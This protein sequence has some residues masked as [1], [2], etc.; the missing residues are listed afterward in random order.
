M[1]SSSNGGLCAREQWNDET[2][3]LLVVGAQAD[4]EEVRKTAGSCDHILF[5]TLGGAWKSGRADDHGAVVVDI[6]TLHSELESSSWDWTEDLLAALGRRAPSLSEDALFVTRRQIFMHVL[7]PIA[8][9]RARAEAAA[10]RCPSASDVRYCGVSQFEA[11]ALEEVFESAHPLAVPTSRRATEPVALDRSAAKAV[12]LLKGLFN[13]I[14]QS[15]K[16]RRRSTGPKALLSHVRRHARDRRC[17]TV[18]TFNDNYMRLFATTLS[19]LRSRGWC[20][21]EVQVSPDTYSERADADLFDATVQLGDFFPAGTF[22]QKVIERS[23][24]RALNG[25]IHDWA[26]EHGLTRYGEVL[27]RGF[28]RHYWRAHALV[29]AHKSVVEAIRP[30]VVLCVNEIDA[31][32]EA[33]VPAARRMGVPTVDVQHG[34]IARTLR[35]ANLDFDAICV[36]GDGYSEVLHSLGVPEDRTHVVGN[37]YLDHLTGSAPVD[38]TAGGGSLP[39]VDDTRSFTILFAAQYAGS[40]SSDFALYLSLKVVLE[41]LAENPENRLVLK[42]HPL[43]EGREVGYEVALAQ[44]PDVSVTMVRRGNLHDLIAK[45]DC[46]VTYS[47]TVGIEA[48]SFQKPVIVMS[49]AGAHEYLP[50]VNEGVGF[51]ATNFA[52]FD[53]CMQLIRSG[54]AIPPEQYAAFERRYAFVKDGLAGSRIADV[55]EEMAISHLYQDTVGMT[56][57]RGRRP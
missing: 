28:S 25:L 45:C 12:G 53:R 30:Q 54:S 32:V 10:S 47:S 34:V 9:A 36:F 14:G 2:G 37:P 27:A 41:W 55:C 11:L 7:W 20:L 5:Y 56:K 35:R 6:T 39:S 22:S 57:F 44:C 8:V 23:G 17:A 1:I 24:R 46:V 26:S 21:V 38:S 43:G 48:A 40:L 19:E 3:S 50:S 42:M 49:S 33:A 18:L 31:L 29:H 52:E 4:W 51:E 15:L 16:Y 13:T